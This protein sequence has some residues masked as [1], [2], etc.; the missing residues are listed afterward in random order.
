MTKIIEYSYFQIS[1]FPTFLLLPLLRQVSSSNNGVEILF[2][3]PGVTQKCQC[4]I[5]VLL[6][7]LTNDA[8]TS[9]RNL[10]PY[11]FQISILQPIFLRLTRVKFLSLVT[12]TFWFTLA[13]WRGVDKGKWTC[14]RQFRLIGKVQTIYLKLISEV[15]REQIKFRLLFTGFTVTLFFKKDGVC[16]YTNFSSML[17]SFWRMPFERTFQLH[18][19][20]SVPF[21]RYYQGIVWVYTVWI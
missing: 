11:N 3:L 9:Y 12:G 6:K 18:R 4:Q 20:I 14:Q 8:Y 1:Y 17:I 5:Y 10:A 21:F 13:P 15:S 19:V 16:L 2:S 7:W